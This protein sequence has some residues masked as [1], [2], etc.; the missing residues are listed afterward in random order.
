[1]VEFGQVTVRYIP[2]KALKG[3][4]E[5]ILYYLDLANNDRRKKI[6]IR[7][8]IERTEVALQYIVDQ[9]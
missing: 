9:Y 6:H 1:M 8:A 7:R 3:V 2:D 4:F 5:E